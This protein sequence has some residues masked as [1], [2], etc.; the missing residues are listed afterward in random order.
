MRE[1]YHRSFGRGRSNASNCREQG[2]GKDRAQDERR[3]TVKQAKA[4]RARN[5]AIGSSFDSLLAEKGILEEVHARAIKEVIAWQL[6]QR[7]RELKLSKRAMAERMKTSRTQIERLLDPTNDHVQLDT[8]QKAARLR[9]G[10]QN[11][12]RRAGPRKT[13]C[14]KS[15]VLRP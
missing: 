10:D 12:A 8:L 5:K 4:R 11:R 14:L 9:A 3:L 6:D 1:P 15:V 13:G 7:R 2:L